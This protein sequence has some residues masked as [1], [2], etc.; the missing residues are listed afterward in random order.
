[1][2]K[3]LD[4]GYEFEEPRIITEDYEAY[5]SIFYEDYLCCPE[6]CGWAFDEIDPDDEDDEF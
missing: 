1:M 2:Y 3:C 4:C 6:C 5:G